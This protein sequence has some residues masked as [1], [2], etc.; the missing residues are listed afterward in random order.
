MSLLEISRSMVEEGL[1]AGFNEAIC[2]IVS[3]RTVMVKFSGEPTVTQSWI[4][5]CIYLYLARDGRIVLCEYRTPDIERVKR[6]LVDLHESAKLIEA[7]PI[8]A[9]L[10]K[11]H[12]VKPLHLVDVKIVKLMDDRSDL[13]DY[14]WMMIDEA[15]SEGAEN[16]A[17]AL[18]ASLS[19]KALTTS[20]GVE[21]QEDSTGIEC[22]LRAFSG[23]GSGQWAY[24]GRRL[25][26]YSIREVGRRAGMYAYLSKGTE[27]IEPGVY[28]LALSPMIVGN[29]VNVIGDM[30]SALQVYL[31][32]SFLLRFK[33][34]D[35][36]ASENVCIED[37]GISDNLPRSTGFDDEGIPTRVTTIISDG[38]FENLLH[39]SK[40]ASKFNVESTGNAGWVK[41]EPWNLRFKPGDLKEDEIPSTLREGLIL[42]NNWYTRLQ[43]YVEGVFSTVARDAAFLVKDGRIVKAVRG[44]RITGSLHGLLSS[45]EYS[46]D[47]YYQIKWWE[48][49]V[50]VVAPY[51]IA[52]RIYVSK[53]M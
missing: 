47:R 33:P 39:N 48:V 35:R 27:P 46:T 22:Y 36:V 12:K 40:T 25:D 30:A 18:S 32:L 17:G 11:P 23:D 16:Y 44:L 14:A 45:V 51:I 5:T 21:L 26:E 19:S 10:P 43:S 13:I 38:V 34:G 31:G 7:S 28:D 52:R 24:G 29:I 3:S 41:P 49:E 4:D 50:P 20:E 53:P 1:K 2:K 37:D 6:R 9:P 42:T 8:Y 15:S